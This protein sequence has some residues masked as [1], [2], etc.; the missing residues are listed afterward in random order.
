MVSFYS[1]WTAQGG[2]KRVGAASESFEL[3]DLLMN[4]GSNH[5]FP[6]NGQKWSLICEPNHLLPLLCVCVY[7]CECECVWLSVWLPSLNEIVVWNDPMEAGVVGGGGGRLFFFFFFLRREAAELRQ[8]ERRLFIFCVRSWREQSDRINRRRRKKERK[9]KE[10]KHNGALKQ[11]GK[12]RLR[13][14]HQVPAPV[15][16]VHWAEFIIS[17]RSHRDV[18]RLFP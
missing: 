15:A 18:Q 11:K 3:C 7:V 12:K 4:A 9:K 5:H 17:K 6:E 1:S 8:S 2:F 13:N 10:I 14:Y 16:A